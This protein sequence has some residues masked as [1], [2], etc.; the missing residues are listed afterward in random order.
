MFFSE[1]GI[2]GFGCQALI[3]ELQSNLYAEKHTD[4]HF[5]EGTPDRN[6]FLDFM[7]QAAEQG[8]ILNHSGNRQEDGLIHEDLTEKEPLDFRGP[9]P[10]ADD[11]GHF[12]EIHTKTEILHYKNRSEMDLMILKHPEKPKHEYEESGMEPFVLPGLDKE[13]MILKH[14][15]EPK[16]EY[17]ESGMEPFVSPGLDKEAMIFKHPEEPK[18]KY[19][20]LG[21]EPF[22]SKGLDKEPM[23]LKHPEKPKHEYEKS[24]IKPIILQ[25]VNDLTENPVLDH[26]EV[27]S[28]N[29]FII[30]AP[31]NQIKNKWDTGKINLRTKQS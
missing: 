1:Q 4:S 22:L 30:S 12:L 25:V 19:E 15:E 28:K 31:E 10:K 8:L 23:I 18:H 3:S 13:A 26:L 21:M 17:E 7:S 9:E 2:M 11:T 29:D 5:Q 24:N 14:P 27:V 6:T 20:E 16:N